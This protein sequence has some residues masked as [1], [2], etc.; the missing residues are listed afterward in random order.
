MVIKN[1]GFLGG[2]KFRNFE[3]QPKEKL[4]ETEIPEKVTVPLKQGF[5]NEV[6]V[7]VKTWDKVRAGQIIGIDNDSVSNPVHAP[8]NGIVEEIKKINYFKQEISAVIIKSDKTSGWQSLEGFM[9]EWLK[10]PVEKIEELIYLSGAASLG[11]NGIPTRFNSSTIL[12]EEVDDLIIHETGSEVYNPS[13]F[14]LLGKRVLSFI[15]GL[16]ILKKILPNA[17]VHVVLDKHQK[18]LIEELSKFI[19]GWSW[20]NIYSVEPK[21]PFGCD[22]VIIPAILGKNLP[23]GSSAANTGTIVLSVQAVLHA[24]EA[25]TQGKPLI[26]K[27]VTLCGP[28]FKE[29]LHIQIRTGSSLE[30]IIKGKIQE[31]E[32]LRFVLNSPLT[33]LAFSDI[34]NPLDRTVCQVISLVEEK[35]KEFFAFIRPGSKKDSYSNTFLSAVLASDRKS[36]TNL[37]GEERPCIFCNYCQNVCPAGIIPHL[38]HHH[39]KKAIIDEILITLGISRCINC[40]LCSYVCPSKIN[41]AESIKEGKEELIRQGFKFPSHGLCRTALKES[42]K[43]GELNR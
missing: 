12:P 30:N 2:Y 21:Y 29:P 28:G 7:T 19:S 38:I 27:I 4:I 5:G 40:N 17:K 35:E 14:L 26:E 31:N 18:Y 25:V 32:N 22:E 36:S 1:K 15:E 10:L 11:R 13:L 39:V 3:G 37:H 41:L 43:N 8:V 42:E 24:C 6:P 33:G 9:D 16:K 34:S 20:I 23:E